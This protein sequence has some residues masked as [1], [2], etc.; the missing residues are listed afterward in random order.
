M[1]GFQNSRNEIL[2]TFHC[3]DTYEERSID[4]GGV[5]KRDDLVASGYFQKTDNETVF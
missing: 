1:Q 2:G 3:I 4:Q 5:N